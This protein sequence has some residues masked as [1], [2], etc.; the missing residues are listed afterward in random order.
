MHTY[1]K[2]IRENAQ[3]KEKYMYFCVKNEE[4]NSLV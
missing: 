1:L 4:A 2:C 3:M